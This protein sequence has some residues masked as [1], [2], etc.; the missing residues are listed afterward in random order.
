LATHA[1]VEHWTDEFVT[2]RAIDRIVVTDSVGSLAKLPPA[3]AGRVKV[4]S[5]AGLL[6]DA[7]KRL[8]AGGSIHRLLNPLP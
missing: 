7:I 3:I 4:V 5:C 8:H 1:L 2:S 6:G